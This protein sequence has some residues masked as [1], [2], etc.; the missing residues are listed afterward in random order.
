MLLT[1]LT[2]AV[3][4]L[5]MAWLLYSVGAQYPSRDPYQAGRPDEEER[6]IRIGGMAGAT[7]SAIER[8][9]AARRRTRRR[10]AG[11]AVTAAVAEVD[12]GLAQVLIEEAVAAGGSSRIIRR[13]RRALARGNRS[14][15]EGR[16]ERAAV[17]YGRAWSAASQALRRAE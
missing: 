16:Y 11:P 2:M 9:S 5:A 13:A 4:A 14:A 1:L 3:F 8:R 7:P 17:Q 12:R 10:G 6:S 15:D